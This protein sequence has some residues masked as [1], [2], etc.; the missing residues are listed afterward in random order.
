MDN[1]LQYININFCE[2]NGDI[3]MKYEIK[4]SLSTLIPNVGDI[5]N[6]DG[7]YRRITEKAFSYGSIRILVMIYL[8][9]LKE[10]K[11]P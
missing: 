1:N 10:P 11:V 6:V 9:E 2:A 3:I 4:N 8:E 7:T 5:V